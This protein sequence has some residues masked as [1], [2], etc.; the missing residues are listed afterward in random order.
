MERNRAV[1]ILLAFIL[2]L[3]LLG[4]IIAMIFSGGGNGSNKKQPVKTSSAKVKTLPDYY[5]TD[6]TTSMTID[7][8]VNGDESHTAIKVTIGQSQREVDII[9]GYSGHVVSR[10]SFNN[11]QDAY[12]VFLRAINYSGFLLSLKT[13]T[14]A[15]ADERGLCPQ[16]N[17]YIFEFD[18]N[19]KV[20]S[21]L[22]ASDCG[23]AVGTLGGSSSL[24]QGLFEAQIPQYSTFTGNVQL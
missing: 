3:A 14:P 1:F 12:A 4:V 21:R 6:A 8:H 10:Q 13:K 19:G 20:L 16:G 11:T 15:P 22:W 23:T 7:G 2:F 17:R 5:N 9:Q 24:L 18:Q